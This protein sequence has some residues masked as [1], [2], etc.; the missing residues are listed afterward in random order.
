MHGVLLPRLFAAFGKFCGHNSN[1]SKVFVCPSS[2]RNDEADKR[3]VLA[4]KSWVLPESLH[5]ENDE[6]KKAAQRVQ[7]MMIKI[8]QFR[9]EE[10]R[11][12]GCTEIDL[13]AKF[14]SEPGNQRTLS[15][16]DPV[17]DSD[18]LNEYRDIDEED[19]GQVVVWTILGNTLNVVT[20]SRRMAARG[21]KVYARALVFHSPR[22]YSNRN[23][24]GL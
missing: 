1:P 21:N 2:N 15:H 5:D 11:K 9:D 19:P 22:P 16:K 8:V 3:A 14:V 17:F 20:V 18:I 6:V 10:R 13:K 4:A 24:Q 23:V 7:L 12:L